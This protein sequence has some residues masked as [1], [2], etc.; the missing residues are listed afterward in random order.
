MYKYYKSLDNKPFAYLSDGSQDKYIPEDFIA[1]TE[2]EQL[3][4]SQAETDRLV[5]LNIIPPPTKEELMAKLL[6][7]QT[8]LENM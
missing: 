1:I 7:I 2:E 8:Q 4:L 5:S 6:E 3:I